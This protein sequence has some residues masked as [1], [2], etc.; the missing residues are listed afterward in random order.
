M[1]FSHGYGDIGDCGC[2]WLRAGTQWVLG[3]WEFP[4]LFTSSATKPA[5]QPPRPPVG[6]TLGI[7][8]LLPQTSSTASPLGGPRLRLVCLQVRSTH[9]TRGKLCG[10]AQLREG[11]PTKLKCASL[12]HTHAPS[13]LCPAWLLETPLSGHHRG[14]GLSA[15]VS[16]LSIR[17]PWGSEPEDPV[18]PGCC[19]SA[20]GPD[21]S[22]SSPARTQ[23][24]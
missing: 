18:N 1:P 23:L 16:G 4:H 13:S 14:P 9:S 8:L 22:P 6:S 17:A 24:S 11:S 7:P 21:T 20:P 3:H 12:E 5:F 15:A 10:T 2:S 19:S